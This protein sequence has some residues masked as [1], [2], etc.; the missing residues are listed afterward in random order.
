MNQDQ[1][2]E[3]LESDGCERLK[4]FYNVGPVQRA[5]VESFVAALIATQQAAPEYMH[6]IA[7]LTKEVKPEHWEPPHAAPSQGVG[8]NPAILRAHLDA[9]S[10]M[11]DFVMTPSVAAETTLRKAEGKFRSALL[12]ASAQREQPASSKPDQHKVLC[13]AEGDRC[14]GCDHYHGK[15]PVCCY[16]KPEPQ[17]QAREGGDGMS[18]DRGPIV[19]HKTFRDGNGFR[20]EPLHESEATKIMA[21]IEEAKRE[22]EELMPTEQDAAQMMWSAW[23][24]L[25]ELGWRETCYGPTNQ[26]VKLIEPGSSGIH[27]GIRWNE[28]P[29]KTW[30][31]DGDY[32]STP[33][34]FKPKDQ[35]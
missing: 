26:M 28:W 10:A 7:I 13:H 11:S 15:A 25:K 32:P 35:P 5:A 33:C 1:L 2:R 6:P 4:D 17:A 29:E 22:R 16:A 20:H 12:E 30:W 24:R 34:L 21:S 9:M 14:L 27:E 23:Y 8:E 31:I 3:A 19:G 18:E